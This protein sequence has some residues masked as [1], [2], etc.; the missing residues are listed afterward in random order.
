MDILNVQDDNAGLSGFRDGDVLDRAVGREGLDDGLDLSRWRAGMCAGQGF[1][2]R[3]GNGEGLKNLGGIGVLKRCGK[4]G[5]LDA[6]F[7]AGGFQI[8]DG[9]LPLDPECRLRLIGESALGKEEKGGEGRGKNFD[10][11]T[12]GRGARPAEYLVH[13]NRMARRSLRIHPVLVNLT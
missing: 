9:L 2:I 3:L 6:V 4:A 7:G 10:G 8:V 5:Q 12:G 13:K 11:E 1:Q